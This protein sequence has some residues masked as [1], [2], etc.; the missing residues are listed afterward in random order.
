MKKIIYQA[1]LSLCLATTAALSS[2]ELN[3]YNPSAIVKDETLTTFSGWKGMQST[4]YTP[5]TGY[6]A[7]FEYLFLAEGGTDLW[8]TGWNRTWA[9]ELNYYE[10]LTTNTAYTN[11]VFTYLYSMIGTCNTLIDSASG[12]A[13]G[14]SKAIDQ[15]V[16][17]TRCLRA[18]YYS[19][20]VTQYGS[21]TLKLHEEK[22]ADTSP[23]RHS[24]E[25]IYA[26]ILADLKFAAENL[27]N[28]PYDNNY[29]RCT[30]RTALGLM[31]RVYAQGAG[32]GLKEEGKSYWERA[33]EVSEDLITNAATYGAYLYKDVDELWA[34]A[35]NRNNKEALF[36]ASGLDPY[37]PS[38][39]YAKQNNI[40]SFTFCN[41]FVLSDVYLANDKA[42]Y[43]YGRINNNV[44][45]PSKYLIDCFDATH[46]KRW[47]NS[48]V[49][50]FANFSL[51]KAGWSS[52]ASRTVTL[53]ADICQKYGINAQFVGNKIYPY[54]EV[55][56][57]PTPYKGNQY[58]ATIWPQGEYSGNPEKAVSVRNAYVHPYPLAEDENRFVVYLSKEY[59]SDAE[60][61]KRGYICVNID[62]LFDTEQMYK[63]SPFDAN[64][65]NTYQL[66]P[67]LSKYN[68]NYD[69]AFVG[70]NLQYK[71]GDIA[72]MRMAEV[73]LIAAEAHQ[74]LG[75]GGKA[76]EY[77]NVLRQRACRNMAD[78]EA[79][80]KLTTAT[81]DDIF[82]EY[83]R[84]LCGEYSR[85]A[86]L[87]RHKA[88][89]VR[90]KKG[91][92]RAAKSFTAKNYLRPISYDFLSQIDN[93]DEYGTNGY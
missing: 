21:I 48:F 23:K 40:L 56:V 52:Y 64:R 62:D 14:E 53:T 30:R 10:G 32:E 82:D 49:T 88:F 77:L 39:A 80:M 6:L 72:L 79:H 59:L 50:A 43:F 26:E 74:Q 73:Y 68:W 75:N 46:D 17:E 91:N 27:E 24:I 58:P 12:I 57:K 11:K 19:I 22:K 33:R 83:A 20:L 63:P 61:A 87:K 36:I 93:Q 1:A 31:A 47:E 76:A 86:L 25:D 15:L 3:E 45:A 8:V 28:T 4:C 41:P 55:D 89:E 92:P 60:K 65:T 37:D 16:A 51:Q 90:L 84:E 70:S 54:A 35:N 29:A 85:W 38:A 66:F 71:N 7:N 9:Q 81:E 18:Y 2:C 13:D 42:N 5:L 44:I 34:Q 67:S 69:G 78:Y